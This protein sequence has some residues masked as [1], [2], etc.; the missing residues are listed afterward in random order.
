MTS[1]PW[2]GS[3]ILWR[4]Y[5]SLSIEKCNDEGVGQKWR[6]VIYERPLTSPFLR[7]QSQRSISKWVFISKCSCDVTKRHKNQKNSLNFHIFFSTGPSHLSTIETRMF[8]KRFQNCVKFVLMQKNEF[9]EMHKMADAFCLRGL[10]IT[11]VWY[12]NSLFSPSHKTLA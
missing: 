4:Q 2:R 3:R 7:L 10:W 9:W 11:R 5:I 12:L 1:R 8:L 6:D